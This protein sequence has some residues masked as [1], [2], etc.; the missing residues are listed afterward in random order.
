MRNLSNYIYVF[1]KYLNFYNI[2]Y[3]FHLALSTD[4]SIDINSTQLRGKDL[5]CWNVISAFLAVRSDLNMLHRAIAPFVE[6]RRSVTRKS[7]STTS[8]S[9]WPKISEVV[10][11]L[12]ECEGRRRA[13]EGC[14]KCRV[15]S[16]HRATRANPRRCL[17]IKCRRR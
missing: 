2:Q 5:S 13:G 16:L 8:I 9:R 14:A 11:T 15:I 12:G 1:D 7:N 4:C 6:T 3:T 10:R 17:L